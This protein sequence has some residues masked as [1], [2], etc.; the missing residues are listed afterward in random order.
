MCVLVHTGRRGCLPISVVASGEEEYLSYLRSGRYHPNTVRVYFA[1]VAHS[2]KWATEEGLDI[3]LIDEAAQR[4]FLDNHVPSCDC[5]YPVR[6]L[7]HE[8]RVAIRHLLHVLRA[9]RRIRA[10]EQ[11]GRL[12]GIGRAHV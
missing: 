3:A 5:P 4:R 8:L 7:L 12:D 9:Q 2:G 11:R 10:I 1:C 6:K